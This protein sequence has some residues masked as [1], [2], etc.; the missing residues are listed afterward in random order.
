[1]LPIEIFEIPESCEIELEF[2]SGK[3][4]NY[5]CRLD[6][7]YGSTVTEVYNKDDQV[8]ATSIEDLKEMGVVKA[9]VCP[10]YEIEVEGI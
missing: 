7:S 10:V 1:M 6:I 8:I 5:R 3:R 4:Q 2:L 9:R